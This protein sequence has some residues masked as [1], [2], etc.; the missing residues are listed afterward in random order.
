MEHWDYRRPWYHGS[1]HGNLNRLNP[2]SAITQNREA[3]RAFSHK[4]SVVSCSGSSVLYDGKIE[5]GFLYRVAEE[6]R[7]EDVDCPEFGGNEDRVEWLIK[8][9]L[10]VEF[11]QRTRVRPE[12]LLTEARVEALGKKAE[13]LKRKPPI[14]NSR[15]DGVGS[16]GP[17]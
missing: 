15:K 8:R 14:R 11:V 17:C 16:N 13:K 9:P 5:E 1:P 12:E 4:P 7:P 2:D 3:A 6:I 10:A